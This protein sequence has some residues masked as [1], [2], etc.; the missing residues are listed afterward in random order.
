M[1]TSYTK[2]EFGSKGF[3]PLGEFSKIL[4]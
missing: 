2:I 3:T 1:A 4:I